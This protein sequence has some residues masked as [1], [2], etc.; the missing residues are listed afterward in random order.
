MFS[1][2]KV[3]LLLRPSKSIRHGLLTIRTVLVPTSP[4]PTAISGGLRSSPT[5]VCAPGPSPSDPPRAPPK[6]ASL[7]PKPANATASIRRVRMCTICLSPPRVSSTATARDPE[8]EPEN[9]RCRPPNSPRPSPNTAQ[10]LCSLWS[11]DTSTIII[12]NTIIITTTTTTI[13]HDFTDTE[14]TSGWSLYSRQVELH[15]Y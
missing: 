6:A 10:G 8:P 9:R 2:I 13:R 3:R 15:D 4:R 11:S 7:R 14:L 12:T 1:F 5:P